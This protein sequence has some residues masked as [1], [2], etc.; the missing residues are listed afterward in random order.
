[1][2]ACKVLHFSLKIQGGMLGRKNL[3]GTNTISWLRLGNSCSLLPL[4]DHKD[5]EVGVVRGKNKW[6]CSLRLE[7]C[8]FGL[9]ADFCQVPQYVCM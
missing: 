5:F 9:L 2:E 4:L 3:E 7:I 8:L 6:D 1:M